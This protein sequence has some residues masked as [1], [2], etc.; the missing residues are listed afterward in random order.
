MN[1]DIG[2]VAVRLAR[3]QRFERQLLGAGFKIAQLLFAV[4]DH[5]GV[6]FFLGHI[7][8]PGGIVK[9]ALERPAPINGVGEAGA[10]AHDFLRFGGI[11]PQRRILGALVQRAQLLKRVVPVK[12]ASSA[13]RWTA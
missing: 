5:R 9:L 11:V 3:Q 13:V 12:D 4:R 6:V 7:N 8:E 1:F 2:V 10:L